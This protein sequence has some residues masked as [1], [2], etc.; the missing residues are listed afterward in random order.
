MQARVDNSK[1]RFTHGRP[2]EQLLRKFCHE[3]FGWAP[4]KVDQILAPVLKVLHVLSPS[5][6]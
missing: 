3:K 1:E 5:A 2:D 4:D 6:V